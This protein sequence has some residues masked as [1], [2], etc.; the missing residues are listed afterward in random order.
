M[1]CRSL[2]ED[3]IRNNPIPH[4]H[5]Q[6]VLS[7]L[8]CSRLLDL[9]DSSAGESEVGKTEST[10]SSVPSMLTYADYR[11]ALDYLFNRLA[12]NPVAT[13]L[14]TDRNGKPIFE[15]LKAL[16]KS[17]QYDVASATPLLRLFVNDAPDTEIW[18][19]VLTI[20]KL[21][22]PDP[23]HDGSPSLPKVNAEEAFKDGIKYT[24]P[25]SL[26]GTSGKNWVFQPHPEL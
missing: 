10:H 3:L 13:T 17:H 15:E 12:N 20:L 11:S 6:V 26:V 18:G 4:Q 9:A 19:A 25:H 7:M 23:L 24:P 22:L 16:A 2:D 14:S 8:D 5:R 1:S 21:A